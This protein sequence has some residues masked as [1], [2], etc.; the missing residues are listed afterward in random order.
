MNANGN[1]SFTGNVAAEG[2]AISLI[3][4]ELAMNDNGSISF[5][6]N[7]A[8]GRG[9]AIY[10]FGEGH[11]GI[12]ELRNNESVLFEKNAETE[13]DVY[14]LRSIYIES[15]S[16]YTDHSVS[17]SV[18][19][20]KSIEFRDSMYVGTGAP[21]NLNADYTKDGTVTIKQQGDILFTGKY[22]E[23]HLN[24]L[25]EESHLGRKASP[26]EILSSRTTEVNTMTNLYGGY[27]RVEDGAIYMGQGITVH[28]GSDATVLVKNATLNHDG[29]ALTFNAG[30]TLQVQGDS[31]V[32]GNLVLLAGSTLNI[33]GE[34]TVDGTLTLGQGLTLSGDILSDIRNLQGGQSLTLVSGLESLAVQTQELMRSVE[35]T[36]V[37][38]GQELVAAD[39]FSNL[40]GVG[41]LVLVY[42]EAAGTVSITTQTIPEPGTATLSLLAL[43]GL[44]ARRRRK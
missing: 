5:C 11:Y 40:Q 33:E 6:E 4:A 26:E 3:Y 30:T 28:E 32:L 35:Y 18:A 21:V 37:L 42:N 25:L 19:A 44:C 39:Y 43:A 41:N 24:E 27:L 20:G 2:G 16:Y 36:G 12:L 8:S 14:R 10:A 7:L 34:I 15:N 17:L 31:L 9:G 23:Q 13:K 29:F 1:I 22:T 38:S